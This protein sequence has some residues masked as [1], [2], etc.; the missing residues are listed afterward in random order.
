MSR[1]P[2]ILPAL[3]A[4]LLA[5]AAHASTHVVRVEDWSA[6]PAGTR[7]IPLVPAGTALQSSTFTTAVEA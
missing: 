6:V 1:L 7:G 2:R 4:L 5:L 3:P